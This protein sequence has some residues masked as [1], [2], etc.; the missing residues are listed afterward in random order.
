MLTK[1]Q[2]DLLVFIDKCLTESGISPSFEEMKD[3][4]GLRSKSSI[5]R[6][7][8]Q[9]EDRGFIRRLHYRNRAIDV[10]RLPA[11][12]EPPARR[13]LEVIP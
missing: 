10:L 12:M 8:T 9:L 3:G 1:K 4:L 11:D 5:H 7:L 2:R 13:Y 6:T